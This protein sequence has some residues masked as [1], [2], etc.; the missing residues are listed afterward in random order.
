MGIQEGFAEA[1]GPALG[2]EDAL[3][4]RAVKEFSL[5]QLRVERD[6][7]SNPTDMDP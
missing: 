3:A 1:S 2:S 5:L 4:S 6:S 7:V